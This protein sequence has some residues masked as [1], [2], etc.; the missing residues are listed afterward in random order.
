MFTLIHVSHFPVSFPNTISMHLWVISVV[1]FQFSSCPYKRE[2]FGCEVSL[3]PTSPAQSGEWRFSFSALQTSICL[4]PVRYV[5]L[6]EACPSGE[7]AGSW[8]EPDWPSQ[9]PGRYARAVHWAQISTRGSPGA[10][11]SLGSTEE[12]CSQ[13][14]HR[15]FSSFSLGGTHTQTAEMAHLGRYQVSG[16][17]EC[18]PRG[19][20]H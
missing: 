19:F 13:G 14:T 17:T 6:N 20:F 8:P 3:P 9:P 7:G 15:A 16:L 1:C 11:T 5:Q 10:S 12:P 18:I 4:S 2:L